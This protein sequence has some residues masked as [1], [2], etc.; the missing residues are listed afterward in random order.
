MP[1]GVR[2]PARHFHFVAPGKTAGVKFDAPVVT[3]MLL[4][5]MLHSFGPVLV[6]SDC[7]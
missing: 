2:T 4:S 5:A 3:A 7:V 6:S 1:R